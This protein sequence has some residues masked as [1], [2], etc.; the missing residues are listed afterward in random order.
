LQTRKYDD[1]HVVN[2]QFM[3]FKNNDKFKIFCDRWKER[4][5]FGI[6][7]NIWA[8]AEGLEIGMSAIDA[9][10]TMNWQLMRSLKQ[11]FRFKNNTGIF[12][13]RF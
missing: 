7:N 9:N 13:E 10:M 6:Q 5:D 11:C 3:V 12:F 4:N 8:F 2:E 1:A